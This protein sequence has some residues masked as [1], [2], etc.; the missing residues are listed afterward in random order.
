MEEILQQ[1]D[2][3]SP[4]VSFELA[5]GSVRSGKASAAN[6][7]MENDNLRCAGELRTRDTSIVC[8]LE[9]LSAKGV[10]SWLNTVPLKEHGFSPARCDFRDALALRYGWPL[11]DVPCVCGMDF[12]PAHAMCCR[13]G[14]G[15]GGAE[16]LPHRQAK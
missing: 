8:Q 15:G 3:S 12:T 16:G 5:C 1:N 11:K 6:P 2:F 9:H 7:R 14:G 4:S 13:T 10:S